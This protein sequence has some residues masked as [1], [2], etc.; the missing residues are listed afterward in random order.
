MCSCEGY[1]RLEVSR[2]TTSFREAICSTDFDPE[3]GA[4][5]KCGKFTLTFDCKPQ[6]FLFE[7]EKAIDIPA[8]DTTR[9]RNP[10]YQNSKPVLQITGTGTFT[11]NGEQVQIMANSGNLVLDAETMEC[12]EY[13]GSSLVNRNLQVNMPNDWFELKP[14][15]NMIQT[16]AG[17]T[18]RLV[19][20]WWQ[21]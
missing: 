14:G 7:G 12:Y 2:D 3:T 21:L 9:F 8:G 6:R 1:N 16:P 18:M 10:T 4:F 5:L 15:M 17:M 11:I 19:P 13:V 20:R